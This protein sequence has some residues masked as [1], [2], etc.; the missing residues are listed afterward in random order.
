MKVF[1]NL[2]FKKNQFEREN[3]NWKLFLKKQKTFFKQSKSVEIAIIF[4]LF[5]T[6]KTIDNRVEWKRSEQKSWKKN[7]KH[8]IFFKKFFLDNIEYIHSKWI[9]FISLIRRLFTVKILFSLNWSVRIGNH[10]SERKKNCYI[11]KSF[12]LLFRLQNLLV[13][14]FKNLKDFFLHKKSCE[15]WNYLNS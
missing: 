3:N 7:W 4:H 8:W 6:P 11:F 9:R 10:C 12:C 1:I 2:F 5:I 15:N 13:K 14:K